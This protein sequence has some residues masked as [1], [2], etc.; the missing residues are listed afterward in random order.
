[1]FFKRLP[2]SRPGFPAPKLALTHTDH[3]LTPNHHSPMPLPR[4]E[5]SPNATGGPRFQGP[6]SCGFIGYAHNMISGIPT[7]HHLKGYHV[8]EWYGTG[9]RLTHRL[10][11]TMTWNATPM[12]TA[13]PDRHVVA[14]QAPYGAHNVPVFFELLFKENISSIV[15][16]GDPSK[17]PQGDGNYTRYFPEKVGETLGFYRYNSTLMKQEKFCDGAFEVNTLRISTPGGRQKEVT[18]FYFNNFPNKSVPADLRKLFEFIKLVYERAIKPNTATNGTLTHCNAAVGRTG[19]VNAMILLYELSLTHGSVSESDFIKIHNDIRSDRGAF[20]HEKQFEAML[21]FVNNFLNVAQPDTPSLPDPVPA[22]KQ[23][24]TVQ[25]ADSPLIELALL[26]LFIGIV[27]VA[28]IA[29]VEVSN[30]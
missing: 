26:S 20:E 9:S 6:D 11:E 10:G 28:I 15:T 29:M 4:L 23:K 18:Q 30:A 2:T 22:P 14:S 17:T 25:P 13:F 8:A 7:P 21:K 3:R 12:K 24:T 27:G 5:I 1:M 16:V 19:T